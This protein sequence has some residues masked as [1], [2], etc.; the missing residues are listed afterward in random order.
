MSEEKQPTYGKNARHS[1][2]SAEIWRRENET[3]YEKIANM[4]NQ[5]AAEIIKL[6]MSG[7]RRISVS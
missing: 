3:E 2:R 4:S 7:G 6:M 5:E 1:E